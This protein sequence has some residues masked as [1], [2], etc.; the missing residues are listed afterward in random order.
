MGCEATGLCK[1]SKN[2]ALLKP[3][4]RF[5]LTAGGPRF[6]TAQPG[7]M[8]FVW[9]QQTL[10][11]EGIAGSGSDPQSQECSLPVVLVGRQRKV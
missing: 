8:L 9:F 1:E 3:R 6:P 5:P 10:A 11:R 2:L 7:L 4:V